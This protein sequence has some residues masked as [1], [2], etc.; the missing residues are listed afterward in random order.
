MTIKKEGVRIVT[1]CNGCGLVRTDQDGKRARWRSHSEV[2]KEA[3]AEGWTSKPTAKG[4][5]Y[6]HFCKDCR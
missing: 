6:D 4:N 5:D 1:T 3:Q 2:W